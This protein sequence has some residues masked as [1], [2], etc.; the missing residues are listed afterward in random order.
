M[1]AKDYN[2]FTDTLVQNL[3]ADDRVIGLVA[4]GSMANTSHAPDQWSDHDFWVVTVPGVQEHFRTDLC[5]LPD[6]DQIVL[7]FRETEH[8]LKVLFAGGHMIEFAVADVQE[9]DV[10]HINSYRI[11]LDRERIAGRLEA[12]RARTQA[13][14]ASQRSNPTFLFGQ[15]ITNLWV[16][17]GRYQRGEQLSAHHFIKFSALTH[18]LP[19]LA[20]YAQAEHPELLDNL[21]PFRRFEQAFPALGAE[22]NALLLQPAP[23]AA[24]GLLAVADQHLSASLPG[25]PETAVTMIRTYLSRGT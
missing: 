1:N 5:W 16:G 3:T 19:L 11:L 6:R 13:W 21:D 22:I 8:G 18:L 9:F 12:M 10:M 7:S 14:S 23:Q 24:L 20:E 17:F 2:R 25:Y 4:A 15:F